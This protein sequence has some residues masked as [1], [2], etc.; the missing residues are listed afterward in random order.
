MSRV[1]LGY[2]RI[3][4]VEDVFHPENGN[5]MAVVHYEAADGE[6]V[7]TTSPEICTELEFRAAAREGRM[8]LLPRILR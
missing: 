8:L 5:R 4:A 6:H 1:P 7:L 3:R 2:G